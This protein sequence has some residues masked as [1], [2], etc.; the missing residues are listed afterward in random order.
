MG[1][2]ILEALAYDEMVNALI[3]AVQIVAFVFLLRI[4]SNRMTR[5]AVWC[6]I[7]CML[8][9]IVVSVVSAF[10]F[11][12]AQTNEKIGMVSMVLQGFSVAESL[13][14]IYIYAI[15]LRNNNL[16]SSSRTWIGLLAA[17]QA[18]GIIFALQDVWFI[19]ASPI[20]REMMWTATPLYAL[21]RCLWVILIMIA[22][23]NFAH[24]SAFSG[25]Y[26]PVP[27]PRGAYNPL[28]KYL[29]ALIAAGVMTTGAM[30]LLYHYAEQVSNF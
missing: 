3:Y 20:T 8:T 15:I 25:D 17:A 27:A 29:T 26:D 12:S 4:A 28:N 23:L 30:W 6:G 18:V 24:S 10:L 7:G 9:L 19:G 13:I 2:D 21:F 16:D 14:W 1:F 22:Y 5:T 11:R